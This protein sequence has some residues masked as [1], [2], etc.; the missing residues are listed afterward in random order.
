[1]AEIDNIHD[2]DGSVSLKKSS[3]KFHICSKYINTETRKH[4]FTCLENALEKTNE[5]DSMQLFTQRPFPKNMMKSYLLRWV[6]LSVIISMAICWFIGIDRNMG[7]MFF[8][9]VVI[10]WIKVVYRHSKPD[11][12][13]SIDGLIGVGKSTLS[14]LLKGGFDSTKSLQCVV[15]EEKVNTSWLEAFYSKPGEYAFTFQ[16]ERLLQTIYGTLSAYKEI[17]HNLSDVAIIDRSTLGNLPF[18]MLHFNNK[19]ITPDQFRLYANTLVDSAPYCVDVAV[20]LQVSVEIAMERI[21][22][23][24][25]ESESDISVQYMYEIDEAMMLISL[26]AKYRFNYPLLVLKWDTL[27]VSHEEPWK[28]I[29]NWYLQQND[30]VTLKDRI[31]NTYLAVFEDT[32]AIRR[33]QNN[34]SVLCTTPPKHLAEVLCSMS[35]KELQ[36]EME[37]L[38]WPPKP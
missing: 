20:H 33:P 10:F 3:K 28:T 9:A 30:A 19:N 5:C 4:V 35:Y 22:K 29:E 31:R 36:K 13:V 12:V 7:I 14:A 6:L 8:F 27:P 15:F 11:I 37:M 16:I 17:D 32:K 18:A 38:A 2:N 1:M 25:R 24:N 26:Y 21:R 34:E 23:R